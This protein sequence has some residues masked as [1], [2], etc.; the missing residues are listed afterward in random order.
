MS[1]VGNFSSSQ[2][3]KLM[4]KGR[5]NWSLE[6]T[7]KPF[8]TYI[9]EKA[10]E[11]KLGRSLNKEVS[12]RPISWGRLVEQQCFNLLSL[13]YSLVSKDR[14]AHKVYSDYWTGMPDLLTDEIVGDIK[15]PYTLTSFAELLECLE[16]VELFKK[17]KPEYYWQLVSNGILCDRDTA[18]IVIYVPYKKHLKD[19]K[20]LSEYSDD[21]IQNQYAFINWASDEELPYIPN[22]SDISD[23]N[24]LEFKIP[25]ED[26]E[27]LTERV[28]MA[29]KQLNNK[30]NK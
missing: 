28:K 25:Q 1:R 18:V 13:N 6:N 19:I 5:G 9:K 24:T 20:E 11:R 7:G 27:L 16:D 4:S 26:K 17:I 22:D 12:A 23:V 10:W 14:Y 3:Y 29:I 2:I 8:D 15:C 21:G 30:L